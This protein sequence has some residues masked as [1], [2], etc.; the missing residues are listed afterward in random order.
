[1]KGISHNSTLLKRVHDVCRSS[2][3]NSTAVGENTWFRKTFMKTTH[4]VTW[5]GLLVLH[6][7]VRSTS[8]QAIFGTIRAEPR[9]LLHFTIVD[10]VHR[11]TSFRSSLPEK[12]SEHPRSAAIFLLG[13]FFLLHRWLIPPNLLT[14]GCHIPATSPLHLTTSALLPRS[15]FFFSFLL[16]FCFL[17]GVASFGLLFAGSPGR[18]G[19]VNMTTRLAFGGSCRVRCERSLKV[20]NALLA[21]VRLRESWLR[22]RYRT[23]LPVLSLFLFFHECPLPCSVSDQRRSGTVSREMSKYEIWDGGRRLVAHKHCRRLA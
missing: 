10:K 17:R 3:C 21:R 12:E 13:P 15:S 7:Q 14:A 19:V 20:F 16:S 22:V 5:L 11:V 2:T 1:M 9:F 4:S 8:S 18:Y 6:C 23:T